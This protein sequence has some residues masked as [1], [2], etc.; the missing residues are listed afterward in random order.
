MS[1]TRQTQGSVAWKNEP[2]KQWRQLPQPRED[3][4]LGANYRLIHFGKG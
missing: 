2:P 1:A 4:L 3:L